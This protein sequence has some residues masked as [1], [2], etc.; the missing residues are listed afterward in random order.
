M[1]EVGFNYVSGDEYGHITVTRRD[2]LDSIVRRLDKYDHDYKVENY[3]VN[4]S[5]DSSIIHVEKDALRS[6]KYMIATPW[7]KG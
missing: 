2:T 5:W 1:N 6:M 3:V 7:S 4:G